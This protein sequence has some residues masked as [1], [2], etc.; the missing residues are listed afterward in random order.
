MGTAGHV[1]A[2][3]KITEGTAVFTVKYTLPAEMA[4]M[5]GILPTEAKLKFKNTLVKSN[6]EQGPALITV[7][8]D[9]S[10][11]TGLLLLDVPI[12]QMQYAVKM[13]KADMDESKKGAPAFS[14][15]TATGEK[16]IIATYNAEKYTHKDDKGATY[17]LWVTQ[18]IELPDGMKEDDFKT[19]KGTPVMYTSFRNGIQ[20]TLTL[21]SLKQ[22][23]VGD[24]SLTVP[25]GYQLK[26]M[27]ELKAMQG[28]GGG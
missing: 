7:I 12:A 6:M 28:G 25:S 11:E 17:E 22:E 23:A 18:D 26:T 13:T 24:L 14:D 15:F 3:K 10:T 19:I 5:E 16:K 8:A 4:Q 2:Q 27:E 9:K 1:L 20:S 21:K